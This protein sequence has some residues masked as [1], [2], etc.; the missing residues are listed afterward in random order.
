VFFRYG[1]FWILLAGLIYGG[2]HS[3]FASTTVKNWVKNQLGIENPNTYRFVYVLQSVF[4]TLIFIAVVFLLPDRVL[5]I[6]SPPWCYFTL[7]VEALAIAGTIL[8]LFQTGILSFLGLAP[9]MSEEQA[10]QASQLH[11]GGLYR[12]MRHPLYVFSLIVIWLLPVMTWNI[13]SWNICVT[14]YL[15]VGSLFEERKLIREFGEQ[16]LQYQKKVP[17]FWPRLSPK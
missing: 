17:A 9:F 6:I 14:I 10:A 16:Y 13:L 7:F 12:Y 3:A 8:S 5:Y 2:I 1:F 15:V 11:T 4:F